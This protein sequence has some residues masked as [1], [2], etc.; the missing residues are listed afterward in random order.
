VRRYGNQPE[1]IGH[2]EHEDVGEEFGAEA[3]LADFGE[4]VG[5]DVFGTAAPADLLAEDVRIEVLGAQQGVDR[6]LLVEIEHGAGVLRRGDAELLARIDGAGG[7][8][9]VQTQQ[10]VGAPVGNGAGG[11]IGEC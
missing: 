6:R 5:V 8:E 2:A 3:L 1:L 9:N 7:L 11:G 10:Q 4:V